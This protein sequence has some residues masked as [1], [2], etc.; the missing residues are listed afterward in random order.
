M[1]SIDS[2]LAWALL[3]LTRG[4]LV[5]SLSKDVCN[6]FFAWASWALSLAMAMNGFHYSVTS[7]MMETDQESTTVTASL[8]NLKRYKARLGYVHEVDG[9]THLAFDDKLVEVDQS[10]PKDTTLAAPKVHR[11]D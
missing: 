9:L 5:E 7:I 3:V 10:R 1:L 6:L 4:L 11:L 8:R 2:F